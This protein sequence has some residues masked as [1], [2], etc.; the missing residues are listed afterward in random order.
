MSK[1]TIILGSKMCTSLQLLRMSSCF[2]YVWFCWADYLVAAI[3]L[4]AL[5]QEVH[6]AWTTEI[7]AK[8]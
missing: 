8:G 1:M 4:F 5:G 6:L 7:S 2:V 3:A